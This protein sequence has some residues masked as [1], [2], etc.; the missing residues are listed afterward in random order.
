M[1]VVHIDSKIHE[2]F[3]ARCRSQDVRMDVTVETL[4][5]QWLGKKT[6]EAVGAEA[7]TNAWERAPFWNQ[8]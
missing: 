3:K 2:R 4:I 5:E 1:S 8:R 7:P 6:V